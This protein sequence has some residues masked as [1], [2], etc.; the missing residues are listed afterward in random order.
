M[1]L[2]HLGDY[3]FDFNWD[4]VW[5]G[6][7]S[8]NDTAWIAEMQLPFSQLRYANRDEHVWGLHVYRVISRKSEADNWQYIPREAPAMVYLFGEL[9][10]VQ[11]IRSS[12]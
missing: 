5:N 3:H 8:R 10:G 11:H 4:A 2:K 9:K 12:R 6:A 7:T 1:D